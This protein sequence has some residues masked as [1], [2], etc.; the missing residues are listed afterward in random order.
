MIQCGYRLGDTGRTV[1][2][3]GACCGLETQAVYRCKATGGECIDAGKV[4]GIQACNL[5]TVPNRPPTFPVVKPESYSSIQFPVQAAKEGAFNCSIHGDD[6][7]GFAFAFRS[8]WTASDIRL[9]RLTENGRTVGT[10]MPALILHPRAAR[11][12]EDPRLFRFQGRWHFSFTGYEKGQFFCSVLVAE[13]HAWPTVSRVWY[14]QYDQR[15]PEAEK[16]W[17]FFDHE[18]QLHCIYRIGPGEHKVL[19]FDGPNVCAVHTSQWDPGWKYGEMRGGASPVLHNGEWYS[20]FHGFRL[21]GGEI[22]YTCGLYTFENRAPFRPVRVIKSPVV[23]PGLSHLTTGPDGWKKSIYY[24]C[25]AALKRGK[26]HVSAGEHDN[27]C[28]LVSFDAEAIERELKPW[29]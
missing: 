15:H 14:P 29:R 22:T 27:R 4:Q 8:G 17:G 10:L 13:I 20:W 24:P 21:G 12:R 3:P 7:S 26:W 2:V 25:G 23:L 19:A 9:C 16:N 28:T 11:G 6:R 5:C 1:E 18:G